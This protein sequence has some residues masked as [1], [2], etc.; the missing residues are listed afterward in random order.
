MIILSFD[1]GIKNL[2]YCLIDSEDKTIL[3]WNV[4]DCS[5]TNEALRVIQELDAL[6]Y[7]READIVLIEKQPFVGVMTPCFK[8][9]FLMVSS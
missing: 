9:F 5:G 3:D 7:L 4:L 2:A 6:E 1:I 8:G